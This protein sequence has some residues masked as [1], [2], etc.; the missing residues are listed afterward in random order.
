[1]LWLL[2]LSSLKLQSDSVYGPLE[3]GLPSGNLSTMPAL[4]SGATLSTVCSNFDPAT[5]VLHPTQSI[6]RP[7]SDLAHGALSGVQRPGSF[8]QHAESFS[9]CWETSTCRIYVESPHLLD[10][11]HTLRMRS[12]YPHRYRGR[13]PD[14]PG[15]TLDRLDHHLLDELA[16]YEGFTRKSFNPPE[17]GQRGWRRGWT[18][19]VSLAS[20]PRPS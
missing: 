2:T 19:E 17:R 10:A 1:M 3:Y 11:L 4:D 7:L 13:P 12:V 6:D 5:C 14:R 8:R 18:K 20:S 15:H 9:P 16:I